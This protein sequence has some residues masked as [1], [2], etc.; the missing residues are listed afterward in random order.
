[1]R[2]SRRRKK[3][4]GYY[5]KLEIQRGRKKKS[6]IE[7]LV[8]NAAKYL[9]KNLQE[10]IDPA[11]IKSLSNQIWVDTY[12]SFNAYSKLKSYAESRYRQSWARTKN[13][14]YTRFRT[15]PETSSIYNKYNS[16]MYRNG[17][18]AKRYWFDNVELKI[19][20]SWVISTCELPKLSKGVH[21]DQLE[22]SFN[23]SNHEI[24][25]YLY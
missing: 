21:Y 9:P 12:Q 6:T 19:D 23:Y 10:Y 2:S 7:Q 20:G 13:E 5:T 8:Q 1:M 3:G 18:S 25:A 14:L 24:E 11:V 15:D 17:H 22:I 16:Y 4:R